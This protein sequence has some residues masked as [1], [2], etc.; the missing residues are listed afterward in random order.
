MRF[1]TLV[2]VFLAFLTGLAQ[3][4]PDIWRN[5]WPRTNFAIN[6]VDNW[7][8]I[9]D[10]G[11]PRD[12]IPAISDPRFL[13]ARNET[14]INEAEPVMTVEIG[15]ATP[16]AY[17]IRYLTYHE[18]INDIVGGIPIAVTFCPLCNSGITF[19]RRTAKGTLSFGVSGKLRHSDMV[20]YDRETESWWQQA[21]GEAIVG[22]LTGARLRMLPGWMES[23]GQFRARNPDGLV[24]AQ[25]GFSRHYGRNPYAG[26][27]SRNRP[28]FFSGEM[29]PHGISPLAR[30]V[31]VGRR[32]WPLSR[33]RVQGGLQEAGVSISWEAGQA[34]ALDNAVIARGRDVGTVRVRDSRGRD[35]VHD[36]MFAFAFHAFWPDGIWMVG[37]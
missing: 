14:R 4:G 13:R 11:P 24:M 1:L 36:V 25:P 32:A 2:A 27:D 12:G 28:M 15:K 21:T 29:P 33:I 34:S 22:D 31:R 19:D 23:W 5:E 6:S 35:V 30:V 8:E 3:A 18:I 7:S 37:R 10:G 26:Y 16:R 17:P 9:L 20:M